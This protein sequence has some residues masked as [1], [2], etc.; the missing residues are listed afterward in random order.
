MAANACR[1]ALRACTNG[2][3]SERVKAA[4]RTFGLVY[5]GDQP[6]FYLNEVRGTDIWPKISSYFAQ[7]DS[8]VGSYSGLFIVGSLR[9]LLQ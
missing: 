4:I 3:L 8:C 1:A 2:S 5:L 6:H 7:T 9:K